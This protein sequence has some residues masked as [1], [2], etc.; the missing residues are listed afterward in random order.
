MYILICIAIALYCS[1]YSDLFWILA[2]D[3]AKVDWF[4]CMGAELGFLQAVVA[5]MPLAGKLVQAVLSVQHA[6][7]SRASCAIITSYN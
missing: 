6:S 7:S 1:F 4:Q 2:N 5:P 3:Q